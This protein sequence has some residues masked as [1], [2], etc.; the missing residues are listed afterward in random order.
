MTHPPVF[1]VFVLLLAALLAAAG[2]SAQG[3]KRNFTHLSQPAALR[4]TP[5][6]GTVFVATDRQPGPNGLEAV[7]VKTGPDGQLQWLHRLGGAG[8][9]EGRWLDLTPDG[10]I[11]A[12]G[13]KNTVSGNAN[14]LFI[15]KKM[16]GSVLWE[17]EY[18]FAA[19]DDPKGLRP[20]PGGGFIA[21]LE[22]GGQL[23]L[24]RM[25]E[26]G[27]QLWSAN[28]PQT[29]GRSVS[30]LEVAPDSTYWVTLLQNNLPLVAPI[31]SVMKIGPTGTVQFD[32][33][34]QHLSSYS[35]TE[36]AKAKPRADGSCLLA[37]RDSVYVLD[38][39]GRRLAVHAL[40]APGDLFLTD[41]LPADD[42]GWWAWGT[43]YSFVPPSY[44]RAFLSRHNADGSERWRRYFL[45]PS[46]LHA[47]LAAER[48]VEGGFFLTGNFSLNNQYVTYLLRTD[49]LGFSMTNQI[50]GRVFWDKNEDCTEAPLLADEPSL[51]G[52]LLKI[53]DPNGELRYAT[54]DSTGRYSV[55]VGAG[56]SKVS[57]L[58][59]NTLW[60]A[61][62]VQNAAVDFDTTFQSE[63]LDFPI[64]NTALCPLPWVD[65]G[66]GEWQFCAENELVV[67]YTNRGTALLEEAVLTLRFDTL[68]SV[69]G[70]TVP[71]TDEG[72]GRFRFEMGPVEPLSGGRFTV[73]VNPGCD[74]ANL[75][76]TLCVRADISPDTTCLSEANGPLL[77]AEGRCAGDSVHFVLRNL[78][79]DMTEAL[80]SIIIEDDIMF[81]SAPVP[82]LLQGGE[83]RRFRVPANGSTWRLEARQADGTAEWRSDPVVSATVEGCVSSGS[84]SMGFVNQFQQSDG[85][86]FTE[87]EC[88][89]VV[90]F[91]KQNEKTGFPLGYG[92]EHSVPLG[93]D[94]EYLLQFQNTGS[95]TVRTVTLRDTLDA[96]LL[97]VASVQPGPAS[98]PYRFEVSGTG[99]LTFTFDGIMLPDSASDAAASHGWVKFRVSQ[100]PDLPLG[101]V[102]RN[103][104]AVWFD[105][106][107][108]LLTNGTWHTLAIPLVGTPQP[109]IRPDVA[110]EAYPVPSAGPIWIEMPEPGEYAL[111][112][113]DLSGR[114]VL[115]RVFS[116]KYLLLPEGDLPAGVFAATVRQSGRR[117]G[118]LKLVVVR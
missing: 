56:T 44:S 57:V 15:R 52:W 60:A 70:A 64:H 89:E 78:R 16:D 74:P 105:Y 85:G 63:V 24:L 13:K 96:A 7:L 36:M 2:L 94:L 18:D 115:E 37:H 50:A 117:V 82:F 33:A 98:A 90:S 35:T 65:V 5:D 72:G 21:A 27:Q 79:A 11:V 67:Q 92:P 55:E 4:Q 1:R 112:V 41:V 75:S 46:F 8:H 106:A 101:T 22:S 99:V 34:Y 61:T 87:T 51:A 81:F 95:D 14:A 104:A 102:I 76:R 39:T 62:C 12:A 28:Y 32:S 19:T 42:G 49:S 43:H 30:H 108:P 71:Y 20:V 73:Q 80:E 91:L 86:F 6:G 54:T 107:M 83:E 48:A 23:R 9:D 59:P 97:D 53:E 103:R 109:P 68:L 100:Q 45:I 3:W 116:G 26:E 66:V 40:D 118:T 25:D 10:D 84:F 88:R 17:R 38:A 58:L 69:T 114:S 29:A 111:S 77:V 47:T 110:F 113:S 93:A 31:A